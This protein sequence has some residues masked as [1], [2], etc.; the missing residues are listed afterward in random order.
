MDQ[1]KEIHTYPLGISVSSLFPGSFSRC[2]FIFS[3]KPTA[4]APWYWSIRT[5]FRKNRN[6]GVADIL[7]VAAVPWNAESGY[8]CYL[9]ENYQHQTGKMSLLT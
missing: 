6:V 7:L 3:S 5:L 1:S 8:K 2:C 4:S 9:T